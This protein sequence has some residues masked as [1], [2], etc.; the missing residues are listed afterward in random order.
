VPYAEWIGMDPQTYTTLR[1][2]GQVVFVDDIE[3]KRQIIAGNPMIK[4]LY[5]GEREKEFE[6]F[7]LTDIKTNWFSFAP[8]G[9]AAEKDSE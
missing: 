1:I 9:E 3:T 6:L 7:Y 2:F 8:M 5:A 4:D